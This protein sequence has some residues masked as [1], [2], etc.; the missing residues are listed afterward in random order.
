MP[1]DLQSTTNKHHQDNHNNSYKF[2]KQT[3]T[4][5]AFQIQLNQHSSLNSSSDDSI[6]TI[7][8]N[9][10]DESKTPIIASTPLPRVSN[11]YF[12]NTSSSNI[13]PITSNINN[14]IKNDS[15]KY[16]TP[17]I[18]KN[19]N[20]KH[21]K[22]NN[23]SHK[24]GSTNSSFNSESTLIESFNVPSRTSSNNSDSSSITPNSC[25]ET[26]TLASFKISEETEINDFNNLNDYDTKN[27]NS[28]TDNDLS[29][30]LN[31]MSIS[32][33]NTNN[34]NPNSFIS[35]SV[36]SSNR[37]LINRSKFHGLC[38]RTSKSESH[39][40]LK[41]PESRN[42][43][44]L[45][46]YQTK[47]QNSINNT[48][49]PIY[50]SSPSSSNTN[51]TDISQSAPINS[52][53]N[54][55]SI[56]PKSAEFNFSSNNS[57]NNHPCLNKILDK[58]ISS[59]SLPIR[60]KLRVKNNK[61]KLPS[62]IKL[63]NLDESENLILNSSIK[64]KNNL[65]N[66]LII[67]LRPFQDY[68]ESHILNAINICPPSILLK[69][70]AFNLQKCIQTLSKNEQEIFNKYFQDDFKP[71]VLF[72]DDSFAHEDDI[73]YSIFYLVSKFLNDNNW[74]NLDS[75]SDSGA[76]LGSN[77]KLYILQSGFK[78]FN[79][80][81]P[82]LI[83]NF[84]SSN[85]Q[86][87][88]P[89]NKVENLSSSSINTSTFSPSDTLTSPQSIISPEM[90]SSISTSTASGIPNS[91]KT[92]TNNSQCGLSKFLLPEMST[93]PIF[94][95]RNY[96]EILTNNKKLNLHLNN[97]LNDSQINKLPKWLN[98]IYL[99][100]SIIN[101]KFNKLQI[102]ERNR[103][104]SALNRTDISKLETN[105]DNPIISAGVELGNKNRYKDIFPYEHSRVKLNNNNLNCQDSYINA[106]YINY[107]KS[108]CKYIATQG[109]L[110]ET[111]GDFWKIVYDNKVP[112]IFSLTPQFE[113]NVEKCAAYWES[114]NYKSNN[115]LI[116]VK[117]LEILN[118][119]TLCYKANGLI[120]C[121]R[122]LIK[123]NDL[124]EREILQ[125]H[126]TTWPDFG[127]VICEEDLLHIVFLK[128]YI[129]KILKMEENP[130]L[131]HCSA[132]CGRTGSF[133]VID[134]CI[135]LILNNNEINNDIIYDITS[136]FRSQR[137][138]MVQTLRQYILIY[139][140]IIKYFIEGKGEK[141]YLNSINW[142]I[143][144]N[145]QSK[146]NSSGIDGNKQNNNNNNNN[147]ININNGDNGNSGGILQRFINY[148]K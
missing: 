49:S 124:P 103:L 2:P 146:G 42:L 129:M 32:N 125:V 12:I 131:V 28:N 134:T 66:L 19:S 74:S 41:K 68:K 6:T 135:D 18:T 22:N 145:S 132:G 70:P 114:G 36:S 65:S 1:S 79:N 35:A 34:T 84:Q 57:L 122:I 140:S 94:K 126:M 31:S 113:N 108:K 83:T 47:I 56:S 96:D 109:P 23:L 16:P 111:I 51:F 136:I 78:K 69:R 118:N 85:S 33:D 93:L 11:N 64:S 87:L 133:C 39:H 115:D 43:H 4:P 106:S 119:I 27:N 75:N 72:Y 5:D 30:K 7:P 116:Y 14:I 127:I 138:F 60:N 82:N 40:F 107:S 26:Q 104:I 81:Y 63:L 98:D 90:I 139:D 21:S 148:Y 15:T 38:H 25:S 142:D 86:T 67:D 101:E 61:L 144:E 100:D 128:R 71:T 24:R 89:I 48:N 73:S 105:C 44:H 29:F 20:L 123:I 117:T 110:N 147:N 53:N 130:V 55:S 88:L 99:N 3:E 137:V 58:N 121:R 37:G 120:T 8:N 92:L 76:N 112:I 54:F 143:N 13:P 59:E 91:S 95:T 80:Y 46:D 10:I 45:D 62:N 50:S 17:N 102:D 9:N 77:S 141:Y 97:K 52:V